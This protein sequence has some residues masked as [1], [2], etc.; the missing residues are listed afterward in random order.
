MRHVQYAKVFIGDLL[1]NP[2]LIDNHRQTQGGGDRPAAATA[3]SKRGDI[4]PEDGDIG[5]DL[6]SSGAR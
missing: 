5:V 4:L 3:A 2:K 6:V 1:E